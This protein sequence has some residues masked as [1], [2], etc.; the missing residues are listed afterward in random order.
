VNRPLP[1]QTGG[2]PILIG[3][4][5]ERRTLRLVAK[6]ADACNVFG[7]PE[8]VRHTL[9]VLRRHCDDVGR[10]FDHITKTRLGGLIV[11]RTHEE[12]ERALADAAAA[13][14]MPLDMARAYMASGTPDQVAGF[15]QDLLAAGLDGLIF[16]MY[17]VHELEP[18]ALAGETL[19]KLLA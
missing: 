11:R 7:D 3:G 9:E 15:A 10:D 12:A 6:Y 4:M 5:G 19:S 2:P 13:R 8:G 17:G 1:V 18:V 14:G 16:N